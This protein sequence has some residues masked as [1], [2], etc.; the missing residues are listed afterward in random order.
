VLE[1]NTLCVVLTFRA[2]CAYCCME[3]GCHLAL[4][5]GTRWDGLRRALAEH[6]VAAPEHLEL[7]LACV[8]EEE[9]VFFDPFAPDPD[10]RGWYTFR[11]V[12]AHR[13]QVS[14]TE[15]STRDA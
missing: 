11:P 3:W 5:D 9:A 8:V 10:R 1:G 6:G 14:A 2:G 15:A 12:A 7:R 4:A 13:Y